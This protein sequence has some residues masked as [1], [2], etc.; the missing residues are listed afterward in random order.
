MVLILGFCPLLGRLPKERE[1]NFILKFPIKHIVIA[2]SV[3]QTNETIAFCLF[4]S[5]LAS[6]DLGIFYE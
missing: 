1:W 6:L 2:S 3:E 5:Q 4:E